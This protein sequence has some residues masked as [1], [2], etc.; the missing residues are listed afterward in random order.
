[1]ALLK[2]NE[3]EE[4]KKLWSHEIGN[5]RKE[6]GECN[7]VVKKKLRQWFNVGCLKDSCSIFW[8]WFMKI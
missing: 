3:K 2:T 7:S 4:E 5:R 6:Y 1:M 8:N